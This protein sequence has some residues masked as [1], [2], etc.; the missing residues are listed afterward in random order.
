M[1]FCAVEYAMY[2]AL[3]G[4]GERVDIEIDPQTLEVE[5][6]HGKQIRAATSTRYAPVPGSTGLGGVVVY[7]AGGDVVS[8]L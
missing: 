4:G 2:S 3:D 8:P 1:A 6:Y 5:V 7:H